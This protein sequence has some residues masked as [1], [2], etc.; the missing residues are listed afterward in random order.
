MV[1]ESIILISI[2][3]SIGRRIQNDRNVRNIHSTICT[4]QRLQKMKKGGQN[5]K[6]RMT[7]DPSAKRAK[8]AKPLFLQ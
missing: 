5:P 4:G 8:S 1:E 2:N 7:P 3:L 6:L